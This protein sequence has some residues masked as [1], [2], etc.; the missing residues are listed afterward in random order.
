MNERIYPTGKCWCG[1]Q[2]EPVGYALF[3]QGHNTKAIRALVKRV[4]GD[5]AHMLKAHGF[6]PENPVIEK[7]D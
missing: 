7:E 5:E 4:Y 1:C 6:G 2:Q 3:V